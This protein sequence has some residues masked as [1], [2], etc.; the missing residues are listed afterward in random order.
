[1]SEPQ[2]TVADFERAL[3]DMID[4]RVAELGIPKRLWDDVTKAQREWRQAYDEW[5]DK[6]AA[7]C[8]RWTQG[9]P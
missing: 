1:M 2:P 4:R 8:S 5:Q 3:D 7:R 9:S 6:L